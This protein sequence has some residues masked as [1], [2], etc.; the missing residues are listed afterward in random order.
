[1]YCRQD[2]HATRLASSDKE[3]VSFDPHPT[4]RALAFCK[5]IKASE[6]IRDEFSAVVTEYNADPVSEELHFSGFDYLPC[7]NRD[8]FWKRDL[9]KPLSFHAV[10]TPDAF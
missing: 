8:R 3:D 7:I 6:L 4:S 5:S 1:M 9:L 2:R 10:L